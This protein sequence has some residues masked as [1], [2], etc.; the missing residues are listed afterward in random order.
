MSLSYD[1]R[2]TLR[3]E[4]RITPIEFVMLGEEGQDY[5]DWCHD[6]GIEPSPES[7]EFYAAMTDPVTAVTQEAAPVETL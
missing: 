4:G 5:L 1:E 6:R 7:A 3:N 2:V